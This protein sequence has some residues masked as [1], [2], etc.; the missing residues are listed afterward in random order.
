MKS[1]LLSLATAILAVNLSGC[2]TPNDS[3]PSSSSSAVVQ[4]SSSVSSTASSEASSSAPVAGGTVTLQELSVGFCSAQGS[5]GDTEHNGYTGSGYIDTTNENGATIEW[6]VTVI[7]SG[8]YDVTVRYANGGDA[9]R[10][11]LLLANGNEGAAASFGLAGTGAWTTWQEETQEI[12]LNSGVNSLALV[13]Q[14]SSGLANIDSIEIHSSEITPNNCE[15]A[16]SSVASSS[17]SSPASS[18]SSGGNQSAQVR[19][20][21]KEGFGAGVT[22]GAG[23]QTV[24]ASTGTEIHQAICGRAADNTPLVIKVEGTITVANTA[25]V[26]GSCN[27]ADGVIELKE[28]ENISIIGTGSGALFDEIGIHVRSSSNIILQNL[29]IRNVKKSGTPT[30]NGGDAIGM[31]S[32]VDRIWIDHNTLE[33]SGGEKDGY[34]SLVDMKAGVTNVTVSYNHLRNSSR[35][36]LVGSSDSDDQN[37]NI[38]FHH[39][40]YDNIEQR[41]PLVRHATVHTYN[42]YWSNAAGTK[43]IHYINSRM[44]AQV[45]VEGNYFENIDNPLLASDDSPEPGCWEANA[46][47]LVNIS[48]SRT[49]GDGA[50]VIPSISGGQ[51]SSTCS[52]SVPY[53]YNL[54]NSADIPAIVKANAGAGILQF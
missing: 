33:A 36:G 52:V 28:I 40:Y 6:E 30:S 31:E 54:D 46:N 18:S 37:N 12:A 27:T 20:A 9:A 47:T 16:S 3:E 10:P 38:T 22:G 17:S 44:Y 43:Q 8:T 1:S 14:S 26:S 2:G 19:D 49:P 25:K 34:D 50:L 4:P 51:F 32:N 35:G 21:Y 39:N 13:A 15:Q 23:G 24:Y 53:S 42:N 29:H 41:T 7:N 45:L 11:G 48:Y 5:V